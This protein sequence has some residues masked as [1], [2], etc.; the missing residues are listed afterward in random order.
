MAPRAFVL[1]LV[2][3][4]VALPA[5]GFQL[6]TWN[7]GLLRVAGV[8]LVPRVEERAAGIPGVLVTM[9]GEGSLDVLVL[10]EV[11]EAAHATAVEAALAPLGYR[12]YRPAEV[13]W[14]GLGSGLLVAWR[15]PLELEKARFV[16]FEGTDGLEAVTRKGFTHV[17]LRSPAGGPTYDIVAFHLG[18]QGSTAALRSQ[19]DQ[20]QAEVGLV[21]PDHV[22]LLAGDA[23][24]GPGYDEDRY[25]KLLS[26]EGFTEAPG[27]GFVTWDRRN[28][29]V[30]DGLFPNEPSAW[31]DHILSRGL[32]PEAVALRVVPGPWSDHYALLAQW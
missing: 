32:P 18:A 26:T 17:V 12:F 3:V 31:I 15:E 9:A 21:E 7:V 29:L 8:D 23:N 4:A 20:L 13:S 11:W 14:L 1:L 30:R 5:Q 16:A 27:P 24:A 25:R 19:L 22:T 6:L 10:Q 28:P 2:L